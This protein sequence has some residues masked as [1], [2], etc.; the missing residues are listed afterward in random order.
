MAVP[1]ETK[2]LASSEISGGDFFFDK[3]KLSLYTPLFAVC[4]LASAV[5]AVLAEPTDGV[6]ILGPAQRAQDP[7]D[8]ES[9]NTIA[10]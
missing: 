1:V 9:D 2:I 4:D 10:C 3:A 7:A 5:K 6:D 8:S